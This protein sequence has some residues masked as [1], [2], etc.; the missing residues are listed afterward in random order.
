VKEVVIAIAIVTVQILVYRW[1]VIRMP[2]LRDHPMYTGEHLAMILLP[3]YS[4]PIVQAG[5]FLTKLM[6]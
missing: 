1:I 5:C 2:V 4:S 3:L 6:K